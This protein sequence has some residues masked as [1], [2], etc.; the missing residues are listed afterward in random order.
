MV[1][2]FVVNV[3]YGR[4]LRAGRLHSM[5][6]VLYGRWLN[7]GVPATTR[8]RQE[9]PSPPPHPSSGQEKWTRVMT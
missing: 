9:L 3:L 2:G 1:A 8:A 4:W 5:V 7:D 6:N